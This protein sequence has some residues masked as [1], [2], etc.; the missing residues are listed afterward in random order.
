MEVAFQIN[1]E[2]GDYSFYSELN[3]VLRGIRILHIFDNKTC[4]LVMRL[5]H[6]TVYTSARMQTI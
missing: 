1:L 5:L 6:N 2:R 4:D 3:F